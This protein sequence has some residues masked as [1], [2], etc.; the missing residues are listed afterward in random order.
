MDDTKK[1]GNLQGIANCVHVVKHQGGYVQLSK[2]S[3]A[4][5]GGPG[6]A[7]RITQLSF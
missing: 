4:G 1:V 2:M 6:N 7:V 5:G 3:K